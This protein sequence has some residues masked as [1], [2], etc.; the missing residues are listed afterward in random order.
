M[1][2]KIV[3]IG[4]HGYSFSA[5]VALLLNCLR[6]PALTLMII[7][8]D[9][10]VSLLVYHRAIALCWIFIGQDGLRSFLPSYL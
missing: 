7:V 4:A 3:G 5:G 10:F 2:R 9:V 1:R 8:L 6:T